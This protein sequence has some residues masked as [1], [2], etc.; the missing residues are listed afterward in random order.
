MLL[1]GDPAPFEVV[2]AQGRSPCL[3]V[4]DHASPLIPGALG[5]MGLADGTRLE[6]IAWDIGAAVMARRLAQRLDAPAVLAGF[7]RLVID[8][9]RY[10][11]D[12]ALIVETSDTLAVPANRQL[13][14]A[15]RASRVAE[16]YRPYHNAIEDML[17]AFEA[18]DIVPFFISVHTMTPRMRGREQ[19]REEFTLCWKLDDRVAHPLL[20]RLGERSDLI[21]GDNVP[22]GLEPEEDY[23]VPEHAM[24]RGL[25]HLQFEVRQD[26]V[27]DEKG[28]HHWADLVYDLTA[29]LVM[30]PDIRRIEHFWP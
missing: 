13:G 4:C 5:D 21:F 3:I 22:Y 15:E 26:L 23:T 14:D 19:R 16:I 30:S 7:S 20:S 2:N 17:E 12:P 25:P 27:A 8:C 28:A 1:P 24:K 29:D 11:D 9:N 18:A 10:L 6:H